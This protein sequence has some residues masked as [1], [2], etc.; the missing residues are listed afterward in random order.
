M[1]D[2][3]LHPDPSEPLTSP[4]KTRGSLERTVS[5]GAS[6][7]DWL[8][9]N[10]LG[11]LSLVDDLTAGVLLP[12]PA[13]LPAPEALTW[14]RQAESEAPVAQAVSTRYVLARLPVRWLNV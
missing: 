4:P 6:Q 1:L 12:H 2:R 9:D 5:L 11:M 13:P 3:V 10:L 7:S 14:A 8:Q